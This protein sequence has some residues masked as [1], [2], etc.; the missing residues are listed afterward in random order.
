MRKC[1]KADSTHWTIKITWLL[2]RQ[3]N[4]WQTQKYLSQAFALRNL[5]PSINYGYS[6]TIKDNDNKWMKPR[7]NHHFLGQ[8][9]GNQEN[10]WTCRKNNIIKCNLIILLE[11][12]S[13]PDFVC[14]ALIESI[15]IQFERK[16]LLQL[17]FYLD[18]LI[19]EFSY[20]LQEVKR[21]ECLCTADELNGRCI[22]L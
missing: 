22:H 11:N 9:Q 13:R 10:N 17:I 18:K 7:Y 4:F 6:L 5:F 15:W 2:L 12:P 19:S 16:N 20:C 14:P 21:V 1:S 8:N 3:I